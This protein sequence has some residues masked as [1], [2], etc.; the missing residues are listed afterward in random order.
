MLKLIE[1]IYSQTCIRRSPLESRKSG[2]L[3]QMTS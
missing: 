2:L 1:I 3:R